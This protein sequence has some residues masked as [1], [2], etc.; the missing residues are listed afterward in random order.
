MI[1]YQYF[2]TGKEYIPKLSLDS[3]DERYRDNEK[4]FEIIRT[5]IRGEAFTYALLRNEFF[6]LQSTSKRESGL[7]VKGLR[8]DIS[9]VVNLPARYVDRF[10]KS[11]SDSDKNSAILPDG[12]LP[13]LDRL[14]DSFAIAERLH[15]IFAKLFDAIVYDSG[16]KQIIVVAESHEIALNYLKV[17]SMLL[18]IPYIKKIGFSI[19]CTNIPD[20]PLSIVNSSGE[21]EELTIRLWLPEFNSFNFDSYADRYYVF[22]TISNRDNYNKELSN[23]AKVINELNLCNEAQS[24]SF[25]NYI[26]KAFDSNGNV[27]LEELDKLSAIYLFN[28][29][30]DA[31]SARNILELGSKGSVEQEQAVI[32]AIQYLLNETHSGEQL[33]P[34]DRSK[35]ES[36][37]RSNVRVAHAISDSLY[38]YCVS[39]YRYLD[40]SEKQI[41]SQLI[42]NDNTGGRLNSF[43]QSSL[44][45]DFHAMVEAFSV[46]GKVL[47]TQMNSKGTSVAANR[48]MINTAASFFDISNC[49][50]RIPMEQ[51]FNG[52]DFFIK[53]SDFSRQ[54]VQIL[55]C[56]IL[57]A[58]AY[59]ADVPV[60]CCE[61]RIK[62]MRRFLQGTQMPSLNQLEI[63]LGV[64]SRILEIADEI[65]ELNIDE[66]FDFIF[67]CEAGRS[68]MRELLNSLS[69]QD[70]LQAD[71]F[72][73]SHSAERRFYESM[74]TFLRER[75][76]NANF[77]IRYIRSGVTERNRYTE[78]F[79][80][81]PREVREENSEIADIIKDID[82]EREI[83]EEFANYRYNFAMECY[84]TLQEVDKKKVKKDM[85]VLSYKDTP[86][87]ERLE[88][89]EKTINTFGTVTKIKRKKMRFFSSIGIWAFFL[90]L[91]SL[92]ILSVPAIVIPASL[93][94][95]DLSHIYS[96]LLFYFLPEF[97][98]IPFG[99][100]LFDYL[101]YLCLRQGNRVKRANIITVICGILPVIL[102]VVAYITFYF[103]RLPLPFMTK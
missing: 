22:D 91:L 56:A 67:N 27:S 8:G 1:Q 7:F 14:S 46:M 35:I 93:G 57:M 78:F 99:I 10:E 72:V 45:G 17:I 102:F 21:I 54:D 23:T 68:W 12:K 64:R 88:I 95:F 25:I 15:H 51:R 62:G 94:T 55:L 70:T 31:N 11:V 43:L 19:G 52:E 80:A 3:S 81:L 73:R 29:K 103:I 75:L 83:N 77:I 42:S 9:S 36:E 89:V 26:A 18:P 44:R 16:G 76:L 60:E 66:D 98:A 71:F 37:Y 2:H 6:M 63:I 96:R 49:H 69:V 65:Q 24:R 5:G 48:E 79:N 61:I 82:N 40:E 39:F 32:N 47:E 59:Y 20:E 100:Y 92:V 97:V 50:Q 58:S 84:S 86:D 87:N 4:F 13:M 74:Q 90:G 30:R 28:F 33:P 53:I 38:E 85:S 34:Q 41:F 101:M